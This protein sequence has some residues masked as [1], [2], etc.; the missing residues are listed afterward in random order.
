MSAPVTR[1]FDI[2]AASVIIDDQRLLK[3]S[4]N[5]AKGPDQTQEQHQTSQSNGEHALGAKAKVRAART[6]KVI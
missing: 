3:P 5:Y 4:S 2:T 6:L 1:R